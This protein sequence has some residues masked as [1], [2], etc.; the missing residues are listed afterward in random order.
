MSWSQSGHLKG[1]ILDQGNG[2]SLIG[3][4]VFLV[5]TQKG[6][7]T[8]FDGNYD[9]GSI[10]YGT[11][12]VITSYVGYVSDTSTIQIGSD[13]TVHNV[14]L[15]VESML[16]HEVTISAQAEGQIAAVNRQ[17][18]D[19]NIK[20]V[21]SA[22]RIQEVPDANAAETL[23]RLSGVSLVRSGGEGSKV[24]IRG[25]APVFNK[26]QIEGIKM[27]STGEADRST[28]LSM[29]SPYMLE[30]IELS[31]AAMA[32]NEGDAIGGSVNFVLRS[33]P[34]DPTF[35]V[36]LQTGYADYKKRFNNQKIVI[37]G[38]K[39]T[40]GK[41]FGIFAQMDLDQ[42]D[43]SSN[44]VNINYINR[45]NLLDSFPIS[46]GSLSVRDIDLNVKRAGATVV[47]DY[48]MKDGAIK[49]SNFGS[50]IHKNEANQYELFNPF[51]N[52]HSYGLSQSNNDLI[53]YNST[54][55][56][57]KK[58][59]NL[60]LDGGVTFAFSQY[61]APENTN[62]YATETNAFT[63][64]GT[65][66]SNPD[67]LFSNSRNDLTKAIVQ[68][69]DKS[70]TLT[71]EGEK[72]A[73]INF[74]LPLTLSKNIHMKFK[75][76]GKYKVLNKSYN[77]DFDKIPVA[78]SGH[79]S[80]FVKAAI[81]SLDFISSS[82]SS[83]AT[84]LP[85]DIFTVPDSKLNFDN[86]N[87]VLQDKPSI[88]NINQFLGIAKDYYFIDYI[89]S[90]KDDYNGEEKYSAVFAQPVINFGKKFMFI[91]GVRVE[92]STTSYQGVRGNNTHQNWDVGYSHIDTTITNKNQFVL[93]M[94]HFRYKMNNWSDIRL[95]YTH[96][97]AR[98][99]FNVIVP[100]WDI[101][102]NS[103]V[104][105]DPFLVP[106]LSKNYDAYL[107]FYSNKLGLLT[108]GSFYK[109]IDNLIYNSGNTVIDSIDI[110]RYG[111]PQ[112][113]VGTP[114]SKIVNNSTPAV[115][116]GFEIEWQTRFWYLDNFLNKFILNINYTQT[117]SDVSYDRTVLKQE[118]LQ[119][120]PYVR[121][122][123]EVSPYKERLLFQP[124]NIFNV[125]LGYE[126][127]GWTAR[128]SYL[129]QNNIFSS[130]NFF[131]QLRGATAAYSRFDVNLSKKLPWKGFEVLA[132]FNNLNSA[133]ERDILISNGN[134]IKQQY[135]GMTIDLGI[136]YRLK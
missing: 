28:D 3:A 131:T 32:E 121:L 17:I 15:M 42:R 133:Y 88:D 109:S 20:N 122:V 39:R 64:A 76:G 58:I 61:N 36:L 117:F 113:L 130:P 132:N 33:A 10:K 80:K 106:S 134:P 71:K 84:T 21:V 59:K 67:S 63:P 115:I 37:G 123:E 19:E 6:E 78:Q 85:Y 93:P 70:K 74:L 65:L 48:K 118:F 7:V 87:F 49:L 83:D 127:K 43:R 103:V 22:K 119:E 53:I 114:I 31:K 116:Y 111:F 26:I 30:T 86:G 101:S 56:I 128:L 12:S 41:K 47:M 95:A 40:I 18:S 44:S 75:F 45:T 102:L 5:E 57:E 50:L 81:G 51:Y 126:N 91:P 98:P 107:S 120:P 68:Q 27:A 89:P 104:W 23:G 16:L 8:D 2:E 129:Y 90:L 4:T 66:A 24:S 54:L 110:E 14:S 136:R 34:D 92:S 105:N 112:N 62:F 97:L 25:L 125:T 72:G 99:N 96:T 135:Y 52:T 94:I 73:Y 100:K 79:G 1:Q 35:D 77:V 124:R 29:I 69:V 60:S 82:L 46:M 38:S 13:V 11:Y 108:L 55:K 9:I